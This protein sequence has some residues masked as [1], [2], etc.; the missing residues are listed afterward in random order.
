MQLRSLTVAVVD[1]LLTRAVLFHIG[2]QQ[3]DE[4]ARFYRPELDA[5]RFF[6]FFTVFNFHVNLSGPA[7]HFFG[8][9]V[10]GSMGAY[11]MPMFFFLS[12]TLAIRQHGRVHR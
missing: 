11:G 12:S 5:L 3:P 2:D 4:L 7:F 6:A 1:R 8:R 10:L 9:E